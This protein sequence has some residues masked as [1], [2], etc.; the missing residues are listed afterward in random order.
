MTKNM[1][2]NQKATL[3]I[4]HALTPIH[5][6][7]GQSSTGVIDLP[8]ARE[9]ATNFPILP[10]SS[11][12]GVIRD[13]AGLEEE[14]QITNEDRLFGYTG[15]KMGKKD[16][17]NKEKT[18]SAAGTLTFTDARLLCL[19]VRSYYGT[20]AY[21]TCPLILQRLDRDLKALNLTPLNINLKPI[22]DNTVLVSHNSLL[23]AD[24]GRQVLFEDIDL[25][26]ETA[27]SI[28]DTVADIAG[29][30]AKYAEL[31]KEFS[32]RFAIVSDNVFSY[33]SETATEV[34]AHIALDSQT[35]MVKG[36]ALWYEE[37][38]PAESLLSSFMLNK[39][40]DKGIDTPPFILQTILQIGG[41]SSV[42]KGL[43][44]VIEAL[45]IEARTGSNPS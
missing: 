16:S 2:Q 44:K 27:T 5:S 23:K 34:T 39:G 38:L 22:A 25:T 3:L 24:T 1:I 26:I 42:G 31:D 32:R 12:K 36:G 37:C 10:A 40:T 7:T 9:K 18:E 35:K 8:I 13:G 19:P 41:K 45:T 43:L 33:F 4:W 29:K 28:Q 14:S 30:L 20:F 21:L 6:G 15:K 17:D 11:I